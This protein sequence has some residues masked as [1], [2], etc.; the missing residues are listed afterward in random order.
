M[1]ALVGTKPRG[2]VHRKLRT[3]HRIFSSSV[4]PHFILPVSLHVVVEG[5]LGIWDGGTKERK[6][7]R[8]GIRFELARVTRRRVLIGISLIPGNS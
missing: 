5:A 4:R 1:I 6:K 2:P 3:T 8:R 7:M